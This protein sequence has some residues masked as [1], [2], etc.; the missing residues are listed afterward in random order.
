[1]FSAEKPALMLGVG[2]VLNVLFL[3]SLPCC[4]DATLPDLSSLRIELKG[5]EEQAAVLRSAYDDVTRKLPTDQKL[6]ISAPIMTMLRS[7]CG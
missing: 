2:F 3:D 1:M 5:I 7:A 6:V 4:A